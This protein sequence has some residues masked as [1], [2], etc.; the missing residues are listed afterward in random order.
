MDGILRCVAERTWQ[1]FLHGYR[2]QVFQCGDD[3]S[4]FHVT[5][6]KGHTEICPPAESLVDGARKARAWV[7]ANPLIIGPHSPTATGPA[8]P[9]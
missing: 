2:V 3:S 8:P 1:G 7:E 9:S 5:N 4:H 6:P